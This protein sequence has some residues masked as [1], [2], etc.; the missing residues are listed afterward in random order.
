MMSDE[1]KVEEDV[2]KMMCDE[3]RVEPTEFTTMANNY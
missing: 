3:I 1:I 2:M